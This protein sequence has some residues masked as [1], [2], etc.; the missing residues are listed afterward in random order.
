M[1]RVR[2]SNITAVVDPKVKLL[3]STEDIEVT[4]F[5]LWYGSRNSDSLDRKQ[6]VHL[7]NA[8]ASELNYIVLRYFDDTS[9]INTVV[10]GSEYYK[11]IIITASKI[12]EGYPEYA[13]YDDNELGK[14]VAKYGLDQYLVDVLITL[15]TAR[16]II[17]EVA[18]LVVKADVPASESINF[19]FEID[20]VSVALREQMVRSPMSKFW[21]QTSRTADLTQM[22]VRIDP[23]IESNSEAKDLYNDT[24]DSIRYAY[25]RLSQ[26]GI[27]VEDIRLAPEC[28]LHRVYWMVSLRTLKMVL[29]KRVDWMAQATLWTPVVTGVLEL[30]SEMGI[31][32]LLDIMPPVK[33]DTVEGELKV[34]YHKYDIENTDRYNDRDPQPTDPLWLAYMD[35]QLP[36][37]TNIEHYLE[38][39]KLYCKLWNDDILSILGWSKHN[40][41][42]IGKYETILNKKVGKK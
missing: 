33:L 20:D 25:Y 9:F 15:L 40:P 31:S 17:K 6:V 7:F 30:L 5:M 19:T 14:I 10:G 27:P 18:K 41:D 32:Y 8:N 29:G 4:L 39:K 21:T 16:H 26:L 11:N 34:V 23:K 3:T 38:M 2:G 42:I 12:V 1:S 22:D 13:T 36:E 28:R 37:H 35:L 24:M